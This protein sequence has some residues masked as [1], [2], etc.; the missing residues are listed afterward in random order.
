MLQVTEGVQGS[1][2]FIVASN[3]AVSAAAFR[4]LNLHRAPGH[5]ALDLH[6]LAACDLILGPP[7]TFCGWASFTGK[8]PILFLEHGNQELLD[9]E[10][11]RVWEPRFY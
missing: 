5:F 7:S 9:A 6:A 4:G 2:G 10:P 3:V 1:V 8:A 11:A